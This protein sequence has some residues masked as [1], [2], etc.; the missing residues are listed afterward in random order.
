MLWEITV[1]LENL[2]IWGLIYFDA[3]L[4]IGSD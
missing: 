4:D 2:H 1:H 3:I